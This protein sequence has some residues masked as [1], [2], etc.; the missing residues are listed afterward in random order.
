MKV[1]TCNLK[2]KY[3]V[4]LRGNVHAFGSG[5]LSSE[6]KILEAKICAQ[7]EIGW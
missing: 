7:F 5:G 2:A 6:Q 4:G 3:R 1:R